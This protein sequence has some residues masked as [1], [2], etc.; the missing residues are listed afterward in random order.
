MMKSCLSIVTVLLG[1]SGLRAQVD[2]VPHPEFIST[3]KPEVRIDWILSADARY[4]IDFNQTVEFIPMTHEHL[5]STKV[6]AVLYLN[7]EPVKQFVFPVG[8]GMRSRIQIPQALE[9]KKGDR[10]YFLLT[11]HAEA[12]NESYIFNVFPHQRSSTESKP[13]VTARHTPVQ[14]ERVQQPEPE[15]ITPGKL[16]KSRHKVKGAYA[17]GYYSKKANRGTGWVDLLGFLLGLN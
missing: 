7:S 1:A 13:I 6:N 10:V 4:V 17:Y 14:P 8:N 9:V 12:E 15:T 11:L 5:N 2:Y 3:E 16:K